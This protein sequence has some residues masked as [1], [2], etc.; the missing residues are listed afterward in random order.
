MLS[1]LRRDGNSMTLAWPTGSGLLRRTDRIG[2]DW[3]AAPG[4]PTTEGE[5]QVLTVPVGDG[6]AFYRLD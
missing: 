2:G 1:I 6:Q 5:N 4:T 3:V